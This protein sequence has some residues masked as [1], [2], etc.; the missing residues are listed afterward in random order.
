VLIVRKGKAHPP[1]AK[2]R[3]P[4]VGIASPAAPIVE[5]A[6][7][8]QPGDAWPL[9]AIDPATVGGASLADYGVTARAGYFVWNREQSRLVPKLGRRRG[10]PL[11][12]AKN[13]RSGVL[14][15]PGGKKGTKTDFVTFTDDSAAVIRSSAAVMQRTTND[16]QPRRLVAAMV[17]PSVVGRWGGFVTENHTIVLTS[18]DAEQLA[19]AVALLNTSSV[20]QRYRRVS[21]TAAV[22][23]TL[24]RQLDLPSPVVFKAALLEAD[25]DAEV[26]ALAAYRV[27][28]TMVDA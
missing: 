27:N 28:A 18:E 15:R 23:V 8:S 13:V 12:W 1:N 14:C 25:G 22:S 26:A 2:V 17:D 11:I 7:P 5:Q 4:I 19:L 20:D 24:L 21:G 6:L 16:K 3:F 10:Y 9:P